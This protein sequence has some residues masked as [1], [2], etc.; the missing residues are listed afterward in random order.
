MTRSDTTYRMSHLRLVESFISET[1]T[2]VRDLSDH[3]TGLFVY[4]YERQNKKNSYF[5][6]RGLISEDIVKYIENTSPEIYTSI[7]R[8]LDKESLYIDLISGTA[9]N[10]SKRGLRFWSFL[11]RIVP[12]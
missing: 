6:I 7:L 8:I 12:R 4:I 2:P 10:S 9:R 11:P 5:V 1:K 3:Q